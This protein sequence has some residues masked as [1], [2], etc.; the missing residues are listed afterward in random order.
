MIR[1]PKVEVRHDEWSR[2]EVP[3]SVRS[4]CGHSK[5]THYLNS[6]DI[7]KNRSGEGIRGIFIMDQVQII[8]RCHTGLGDRVEVV[9]V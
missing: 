4:C 7:N 6:R 9:K 2:E 1:T 5:S 3:S 8:P